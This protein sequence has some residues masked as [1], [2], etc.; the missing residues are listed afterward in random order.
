MALPR[1]NARLGN[2][3]DLN[4]T[5]FRDGVPTDPFAIRKVEVYKSAVQPENLVAEFPVLS[6]LDPNY[7]A[8]ITKVVDSNNSPEPGK[9]SLFWDIPDSG[10]V[11]PDI[12]FDVWY[13]IPVDPG[14]G[15]DSDGLTHEE[16]LDNEDYWQKCCNRFWI[17]QDGFH[18]DDGL[19]T[20]R[21]GFEAMDLKFTQ[22]EVRTLEVGLMPL[23]LYDFNYN[24]VAPLIPQL[25]A[26]FSLRTDNC[27]TLIDNVPMR[28]GLRQGS[29][30]S[31]PFVL[32]YTFDT[33]KVLR[34]SYQYQVVIQLP[35]GESRASP[36]F[37]IQVA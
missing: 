18:C 34:G 36:Y 6:P 7:P 20:I 12:F 21:F 19:E 14:I 4:I 26:F 25:K 30:R 27:E 5:F 9:F 1:I 11:V 8:P 13:Y 31:N 37:G 2:T 29:Y 32:Q 17:Q 16:L 33:T 3:V 24:L 15:T 23:P 35:N 10:I 22:P 28:I